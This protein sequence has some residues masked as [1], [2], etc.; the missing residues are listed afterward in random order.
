MSRLI[1]RLILPPIAAASLL[2][3]ATGV[4]LASPDTTVSVFNADGTPAGATVCDFY[5]EFSSTSGG[6]SG[7]WELRAG[8]ATGAVVASGS[9]SVTDSTGDREPNTGTITFSNGTYV[10]LWD[11][12]PIVDVSRGEL[13]IVVECEEE[14]QPPPATDTPAPTFIQSVAADTDVPGTDVPGTD[15]PSQDVAGDTDAPERT[16]PDTTGFGQPARPDPSAW[17]GL[18]IVMIGLASFIL[19]LTPKG[20]I[21]RR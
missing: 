17:T 5:F 15:V 8:T 2:M 1:R 20:R 13:Q 21:G 16:L 6:E 11:D 12:E 4:A 19:A 3:A 7:A 10:L 14:T 18:L 9:Y